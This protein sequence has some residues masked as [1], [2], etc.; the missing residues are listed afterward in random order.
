MIDGIIHRP[1]S[2]LSQGTMSDTLVM[3]GFALI[4]KTRQI[5]AATLRLSERNRTRLGMEPDNS[6]VL[7]VGFAVACLGWRDLSFTNY[8]KAQHRTLAYPLLPGKPNGTGF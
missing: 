7:L 1:D 2:L 8:L 4:D 5:D 6:V 3:I